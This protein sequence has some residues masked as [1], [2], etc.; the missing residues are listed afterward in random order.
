MSGELLLA[1]LDGAFEAPPWGR[2]LD[3]LRRHTGSDYASLIFRPPGLS[4]SSVLHLY[5]GEC[6]PPKVQRLYRERFYQRDPMPYHDMAEGRVYDFAALLPPGDPAGD[7]YVREV[8]APSGMNVIRMMRVIEPSGVSGWLSITRRKGDFAP[9]VTALLQELAPYLRSVLRSFLALERERTSA[10]LAGDAIQRLDFG[11]IALDSAARVLEADPQGRIILERSQALRI[12]PDGRLITA[13]ARQGR[14]IVAAVKAL[15]LKE[16][17]RPR[18][19]VLSR[20]PWLDMLLVPAERRAH[21]PKA[22]PA[23]IAYVHGD[24]LLSADRCEQLGQMFGLLPSESRLALALGRGMSIME[25]ATHLGLTQE[26]AR[27]YS[28]KIYA[29]MGARG[30]PDLVRFIHRSVLQIA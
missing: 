11:W 24:S 7:A 20:D 26:T 18:A 8:M 22:V 17:A 30:Q 29:K 5:S 9:A 25:A 23:V 16:Q 14:E 28:K 21:S 12:G 6:S 19:M 13:S 1:L 10:Q 27:T 15:A 4:P 2:F 3:A